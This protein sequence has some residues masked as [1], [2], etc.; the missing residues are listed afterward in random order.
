MPFEIN[1]FKT[2]EE[3]LLKI[4]NDEGTTLELYKSLKQTIK[5]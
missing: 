2:L 4:F 3:A 5:I 1:G